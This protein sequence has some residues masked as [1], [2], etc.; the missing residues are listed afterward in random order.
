MMFKKNLTPKT[1]G[2]KLFSFR[3]ITALVVLLVG[4]GWIITNQEIVSASKGRWDRAGDINQ[5]DLSVDVIIASGL[6]NPVGITHAGD[7][8]GR[9]FI[10]EKAGRIRV[11]RNGTLLPNPFLDI[12]ELVNSEVERGLLGLAFHPDYQSNGYFYI[13]YTRQPDGSI[14]IARYTVSSNPDAADKNSAQTILII[15]HP[16]PIHNAGQLTFGSDGMLYIGIGDSDDQGDPNNHAQRLD[17][18]YGKIL[19]IDVDNGDPYSV[20]TD[21]PFVGSDGLDE[22][23]MYGL[24]NPWRFSF[25]RQNGDLFIGDV[26]FNTWEEID[27]LPAGS[28]PGVNFGWR[29]KEG[30]HIIFE[31]T[32]PCNDP[33]AVAGMTN[34][35]AE[36]NHN[37]GRSITGGYIYRGS[38]SSEMQGVYFFGDFVSGN[39]WTLIKTGNG[40]W[41]T[42]NLVLETGL[43]ISSFGE[44]ESGEIYLADFYGGTIRYLT[45]KNIQTPILTESSLQA[46]TG[47]ADLG[48]TVIY[49]VELINTGIQVPDL[50]SLNIVVPPGLDYE[51]RSLQATFGVIDD[52]KAPNLHWE[53]VLDTS[54]PVTVTYHAQVK[55]DSEGSQITTAEAA[56]N[57]YVPQV[58]KH[59][60]QIPR[61][62]VA[63]T[64]EDFFFPGTQPGSLQDDI[65]LP[66]TCEVCHTAP[67]YNTWR[68]SM[69]GQA[70]HD[71]LFWAAL[72]VAN[73][74]APNAGEYCLRCHS[75]KGWFEG[76][77]QP[78]DGSA[79]TSQDLSNGVT[80]V[81]CHRAVDPVNQ[82]EDEASVRDEVIRGDVAQ[83]PPADHM[84]S[85]MLVLD[86]QDFRRGPFALGVD[87]PFHPNQTFA[88]DFLSRNTDD[89]VSRS[90]LCGTCHNVENPVL[91]WDEIKGQFMPNQHGIQ[92]P[93]FGEGDLFPVETTFDEW[94]NSEY[95]VY[96]GVLAP[97]FA[98]EKSDGHVGACQDCHMPR[99]T[100][101]AAQ[102]SFEPV[103]RD[104]SIENGCLPIHE[105]VGGNTWIP[106][107]LQDSRW[108]LNSLDSVE[109]L[110]QTTYQSRSM[111][112]KAASLSVAFLEIEGLKYAKVTVINQTGHKLPTG[113]AEGRRMWIN[114][115]AF[116]NNHSLI[117]E[118]GAYE[119]ATGELISDPQ[120]KVYEVHQAI[121]PELSAELGLPAGPSFHFVLN[122]SVE[123]D[124]RIPP[125]G[126]TN[127]AFNR[128][129]LI[130]VGSV[131]EDG[132]Y[133]DET[134][135]NI[136]LETSYV[137]VTLYY[138]TTSK[139]YIDF[140]KFNGGLDSQTLAE[141]W[142]G[143]PSPPELMINLFEPGNKVYMP[144][145]SQD[146]P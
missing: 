49:S 54:M 104:C 125:R 116:N 45:E 36:Y 50:L 40:N 136:P 16:L 10:Q 1:L 29:C 4:I 113:Y 132:Q 22:I 24:R 82:G 110:N 108:R 43:S 37:V 144:A 57:G 93:A 32:P 68:G 73:H 94:I 67:I 71:P 143:F 23:W 42:P 95:A 70:G 78:A 79:L 114:L 11:I 105:F 99:G 131:Y 142:Q 86:Q 8:S 65:T 96:P 62:V 84:G 13:F 128:P 2:K 9:L 69:M 124:N 127:A 92:A 38:L 100:G 56:G 26:G 145:V 141:I 18:L 101:I 139:E 119:S 90:R 51:P 118:S 88:T 52:S 129:G 31:D 120:L 53:G 74:D 112:S 85:A 138:Q 80:C 48:E 15:P 72:E 89:Y 81:I 126:F 135:Y 66:G 130:P 83:L 63:T 7:G 122:N 55:T 140:L 117:Y 60:L 106:Q 58:L 12:R 14:V 133:W 146:K 39:I 76:R 20:P 77:S 61:P 44:D 75:A 6:V 27:Y 28:N 111:L 59:A 102:A 98:G 121:S 41:S 91:S 33:A 34:P 35:V 103:Y 5:L 47:I 137:I 123:K 30:N 107:V 17:V 46:N 87:F 115:K 64:I 3:F 109:Y 97:Q 19:R 21:N 25:D 134:T